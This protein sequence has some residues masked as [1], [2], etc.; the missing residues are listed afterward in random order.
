MPVYKYVAFSFISIL[1]INGGLF[2]LASIM[3]NGEFENYR[4]LLI[5]KSNP[6]YIVM[7][8]LIFPFLEES[9]FRLFLS[10]RR[11]HLLVSLSLVYSLFV[12]IG[13]LA[14]WGDRIENHFLTFCWVLIA[15]F[16]KAILLLRIPSVKG[17]DFMTSL[18][19]AFKF[20]YV[21]FYYISVILFGAVHILFQSLYIE[22]YWVV[23]LIS[24]TSYCFLGLIFSGIRI[25]Y[26]FL[27]AVGFHALLNGL[28]FL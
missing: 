16:I 21:T 13:L 20:N 18:M 23:G 22:I 2:Y 3:T 15:L 1:I 17:S 11:N 26:G 27:Y 28:A 19:S 24:F 25:T 9:A 8:F 6:T 10:K 4:S 7:A 5:G 14:L 12:S